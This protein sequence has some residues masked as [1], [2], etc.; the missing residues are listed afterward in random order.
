MDYYSTLGVARNASPED[1]KKAYTLDT[2][3]WRAAR[4]LSNYYMTKKKNKDAL[5]II[6]KTYNQNKSN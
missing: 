3:N 1:L 6:K 2:S 5:G 4:A